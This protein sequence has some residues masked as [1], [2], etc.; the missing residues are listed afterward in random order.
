MKDEDRGDS[1]YLTVAKFKSILDDNR[2]IFREAEFNCIKIKFD[3]AGNKTINYSA[4][5]KAL[6]KAVEGKLREAV[7]FSG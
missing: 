3:L 7:S 2:V 6:N 1:K 5:I 4:F